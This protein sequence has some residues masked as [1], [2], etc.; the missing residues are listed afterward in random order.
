MPS[1]ETTQ[2]STNGLRYTSKEGGSPFTGI[3]GSGETM[4]CIKCGRHKLR[5]AGVFRRY[6]T[7]L[8]FFCFDCKPKGAGQLPT[9]SGKPL[10]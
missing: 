3:S 5:S 2:I 6:L 10:R 4:S 8:L 7:A 9:A 1:A